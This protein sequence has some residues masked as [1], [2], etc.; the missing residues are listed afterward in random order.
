MSI[1][2]LEKYGMDTTEKKLTV[3][4]ENWLEDCKAADI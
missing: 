2:I 1:Y 3:Y 4:K